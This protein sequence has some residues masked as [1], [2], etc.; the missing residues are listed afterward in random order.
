MDKRTLT[1]DTV[2]AV[3]PQTQCG[4]C[5][6]AGCRPYA[7]AMLTGDANINAC[8]PGG[9][10]TLKRLAELFQID[11]TPYLDDVEK[12]TRAPSIA[13]IDENACIGCTKCIKAC[14][15]DAILGTGK[16][17]HTVITDE[18]TGCGL[19]VAPCPVDCIE[20]KPQDTPAYQRARASERFQARQLRQVR[21]AKERAQRHA[22]A[23]QLTQAEN[24][25]QERQAK[26]AYI[27]EALARV[28][29]KKENQDG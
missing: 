23:R 16:Q 1:V 5:S 2:D 13:V 12:Q 22:K 7:E 8:P 19:C 25:Q 14:P 24:R 4:E 21:L 28:K 20:M 18:C 27:A 17:M 9:V 26:K 10:A 11:P 15:V 29:Q 6:Y 3:L